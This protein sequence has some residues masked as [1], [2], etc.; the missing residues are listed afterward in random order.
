MKRIVL[1]IASVI[2]LNAYSQIP[3]SGMLAGY[4][5]AGNANDESG[6]GHHGIVNGAVLTSNRIGTP[7]EAYRF[8]GVNDYILVP[9]SPSLNPSLRLTLCAEVKPEGFYYGNCQVNTILNK[10][11]WGG[12]AGNF[13]LH[14]GDNAYDGENCSN[15]D[16]L[17]QT[18]VATMKTDVT[19]SG[20]QAYTPYIVKNQWYCVIATFDGANLKLYVDA[21]EKASVS[22][23]AP[24]GSNTD[25]LTFGHTLNTL[26][27]YWFEG[28]IDDIR[29]YDRVIDST[30]IVG[31]CSFLAGID[32]A[33]SIASH[34]TINTLGNGLYELM[35]DRNYDKVQ[36]NVSSILGQSI[37]DGQKNNSLK[38]I[39]DIGS[40]ASGIY[41]L[42]IVTEEGQYT[43][44]LV[45]E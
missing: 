21:V 17:H 40:F 4:S 29:I 42:N 25:S 3:P 44:K 15:L 43:T 23:P 27:P 41:L 45:R 14:F 16:T 34:V 7:N 11:N 39:I 33:G 36:V 1:I 24:L 22:A 2:S 35:L 19:T 12:Q 31:Y 18:F 28:V 6:N 5:F 37:S 38:Q 13:A 26:F 10:G 30:E 20:P 32:E 9:F 8:D